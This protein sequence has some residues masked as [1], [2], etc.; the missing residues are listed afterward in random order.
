MPAYKSFYL[1]ESTAHYSPQID[2]KVEHTKIQLSIDLELKRIEGTCSH[3]ISSVRDGVTNINLDAC[4]MEVKAV[5]I[6]GAPC[7]FA[8]DGEKLRIETADRLRSIHELTV[9]YASTPSEGVYFVNPDREHP[10]KEVQAWTHSEAEFARYWY[11]CYDH[12]NGKSTSEL[13][14]TAPAGY[15]VVSNGELVSKKEGGGK[16]T[17][18]W[19][20]DHPH[21]SYL[22]SFVV[23]KFV[24]LDQESNGTPLQ[25]F[26]PVSKKDDALRYFGETPKMVS[27]FEEVTGM[28]YPY[29]KYSQ[30]TVEDFIYGGM[31]NIGATTL[32]TTYFPDAGSEEDFQ[33]SYSLTNRNAV[34]LVAHELAHQWF[35]D[36]VTCAD[37]SHAWLNEGFA[38]YMQAL[39]VERSRGVDAL[40]WDL[41]IK[42]EDFFDEDRDVHRRPMVERRYV[43]ADDMFEAAIY[44]KGAWML[45]ELRYIMGDKAFFGGIKEYLARFAFKNADTHDF[46]KVMEASSGLSL[47]QFFEQSFFRAGYPELEVDYSWDGGTRTASLAVRQV[48]KLESETPVFSLPCDVV[49]YTERGRRKKR[50]WLDSLDQKFSFELDSEPRIVELDPEEWL[51]KKVNFRRGT[52]L[53]L[54]QLEGSE[55]ASSRA[56]AARLL[57][58]SKE[59]SAVEPLK[60]AAM[61]EQFWYASASAIHALGEIGTPEALNALLEVGLPR[62][63]RTRRALAEALG[64]F[65][66]NRV[67]AMLE[68]L[69]RTDPSPYVRCE[70]AISLAKSVGDDGLPLLKETMKANSPNETLAEACMAAMGH[71][72]S[73]E[74]PSLILENLRYGKPSR[75]RIGATRAIK[76]RGFF[77]DQEVNVLKQILLSDKEF[78]VRFYLVDKILSAVH[79]R[80]FLDALRAASKI[81]RDPRVRRRSL[82]VYYDI[83]GESEA[84]ESVAKLKEEVERLRKQVDQLSRPAPRP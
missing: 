6:D 67:R 58:E 29:S 20:E 9:E 24:E 7:K 70:A 50:I 43:Y 57:G 10:E 11:P 77:S 53:L 18:H 8:Y 68:Q 3:R 13:I 69:I 21:S 1:P 34:N 48:Q 64:K 66:D 28:K 35:G 40:R 15:T 41:H 38:T 26:F 33:T 16:A 23:A 76:T 44:E 82:E 59:S 84:A 71:L 19:K 49:F 47:E 81:D 45:H 72:K 42:A 17:W 39:Y 78:R 22:N 65:R 30:A 31:E 36:L 52:G 79:D 55:D 37:W 61:R 75:V 56:A 51:L 60:K 73:E 27:F 12:P 83:L 74:V 54:N 4:G 25:Y 32:T 46:R 63:R 2:F 14:L 62:H 80:R 5:A